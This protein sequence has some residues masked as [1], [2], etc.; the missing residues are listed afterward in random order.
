MTLVIRGLL[1][2]V[3]RANYEFANDADAQAF[4]DCV[5]SGGDVEQCAK[6]HGCINVIPFRPIERPR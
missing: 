3:D 5:E 4:F 2:Q 6:K 1:V